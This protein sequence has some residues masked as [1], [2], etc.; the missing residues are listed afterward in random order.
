MTFLDKLKQ[1]HP[2]IAEKRSCYWGCPSDYDYNHE[3]D[4]P[5]KCETYAFSCEEC[6][7][8]EYIEPTY[9]CPVEE[10]DEDTIEGKFTYATPVEKETYSH[11]EVKNIF[12]IDLETVKGLEKAAT[13]FGSISIKDSGDRTQFATGAVRDMHEGKGRC[14]LLPLDVVA[15]IYHHNKP[16]CSESFIFYNLHH[17]QRDGQIS[18]LLMVLDSFRP[19][20]SVMTIFLEVAKHFEDGAK[21]YGEYNWQKGIPVNCYIDSAVRHYLKYLRGD[22]DERHDRAFVWN[23]LCCIWTCKHKPELNCYRKDEDKSGDESLLR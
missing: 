23:I 1:D 10:K 17:F 4:M 6:W 15:C 16:D 8:R 21:K 7:N 11:E 5:I 18:H 9:H 2:A 20:D 19:F 12:G 22:E 14:D 13:V 3:D